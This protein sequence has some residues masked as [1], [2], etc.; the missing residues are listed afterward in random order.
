VSQEDVIKEWLSLLHYC[1]ASNINQKEFK[2]K[3]DFVARAYGRLSWEEQGEASYVISKEIHKNEPAPSRTCSQCA[4][5]L[6]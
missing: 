5:E 1:Q 3:H 4:K 2:E 6:G